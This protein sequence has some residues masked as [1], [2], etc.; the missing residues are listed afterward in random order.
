ISIAPHFKAKHGLLGTTFGGSYLACAAAI[1][2]LEVIQEEK[3]IE[4]AKAKGQII[5][6]KLHK[7]NQLEK[8]RGRGLM[9]G[10][11]PKE[12]VQDLRS[13]LL[14][15]H[16]IFTGN[17]KP[18]VVRLLPSLAIKDQEINEFFTAMDSILLN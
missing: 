12:E 2:V 10:F 4:N 11:D 16:K 13:K 5:I 7:Y 1:A 9:I 14:L 6:G 17:A 3:L 8:I 15:D 18:N